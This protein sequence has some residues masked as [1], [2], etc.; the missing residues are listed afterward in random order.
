MKRVFYI[1]FL[2]IFVG[3]Y[4]FG[5]E[6][7]CPSTYVVRSGL[8]KFISN[9]NGSNFLYTKMLEQVLE[10]QAQKQFSG[11]FDVKLKSF[12]KKDLKEGKFK[13]LSATGENIKVDGIA[14]DKITINSICEYNQ[15]AKNEN[16]KYEFVTDFPA[17]ITFELTPENI[18]Q[19][20]N[21]P[22]FQ[23]K[24]E[25]INS[26]LNGFL[27]V[28]DTNFDIKDGKL[29]YDISYTL[30]FSPKEQHIS[31]KSDILYFDNT[32]Y[33]QSETANGKSAVMNFFK[34]T[35]ALNYINPLDFSTKFLQNNNIATNIK[36]VYIKDD[37]VIVE[38]FLNI[39]K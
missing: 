17:N 16:S 22:E 32:V 38:A 12:S 13:S 30:P 11:H 35:N 2:G 19:I 14:I 20:K 3:N 23:K 27:S 18:N 1:L 9:A 29:I 7:N 10:K 15:F 31:V 26:Q 28:N 37:K 8:S 34:L 36:N 6:Y 25:K 4:A 5:T 24:L 21:L 33:N 39:T